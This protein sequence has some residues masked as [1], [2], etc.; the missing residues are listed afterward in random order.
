M[1]RLIQQLLVYYNHKDHIKTKHKHPWFWYVSI[2]IILCL[3]VLNHPCLNYYRNKVVMSL[4]W[5]PP[6]KLKTEDDG[7]RFQLPNG[8]H[9]KSIPQPF[10]FPHNYT[11]SVECALMAKVVPPEAMK[12]FLATI[13]R[14][15]YA[16]KCYPTTG[17]YEALGDEIIHRYPFMK[18]PAGCPYV[19]LTCFAF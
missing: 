7:L 19:S 16:I 6:K 2:F 10:P 11:P 9:T 1:N 13:A 15:V 4:L 3:P 8:K 5:H 18:S 12:K 14:A 17:E